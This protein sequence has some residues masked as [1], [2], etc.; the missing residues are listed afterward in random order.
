MLTIPAWMLRVAAAAAFGIAAFILVSAGLP[1]R[2]AYTG[3]LT[4]DGRT[5]APEIGA[6]APPFRAALISGEAFEFSGASGRPTLINFWATWCEPCI[7]EMPELQAFQDDYPAVDVIAVN[8][9]E[10]P[11]AVQ[12]WM[13]AG[14]FTLSAPLDFDGAI[15]ARYAL[16]GQPSTFILSPDGVITHI[17][18]GMTTRDALE[19]AFA[20]FLS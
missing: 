3:Q 4:T 2:A 20:P 8:L 14:G 15:A 17:T 1:Q 5:I 12:A 16:R 11:T 18:F 10:S 7:L 13:D 6:F 9:G 19:Q